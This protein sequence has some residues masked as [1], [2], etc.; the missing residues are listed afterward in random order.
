MRHLRQ[1]FSPLGTP[2]GCFNA[3]NQFYETS[4]IAKQHLGVFKLVA[5][6]WP[7]Y[8]KSL[9]S[10]YSLQQLFEL[11]NNS[12]L[13]FSVCKA[14]Q[15]QAQGTSCSEKWSGHHASIQAPLWAARKQV[16]FSAAQ[17]ETHTTSQLQKALD[18][19]TANGSRRRTRQEQILR[20]A[21]R[22]WMLLEEQGPA[23]RFSQQYPHHAC[24]RQTTGLDGTDLCSDPV[25]PN[26]I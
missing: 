26:L 5:D 19:C 10:L 22:L 21:R 2:E 14:C 12:S 11:L 16:C 1:W 3:Q 20:A 15:L 8:Y 17:K 25:G 6:I 18:R 13:P 7:R 9:G 24:S 23:R 4:T